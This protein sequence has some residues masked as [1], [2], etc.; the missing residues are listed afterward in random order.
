MNFISHHEVAWQY[1]PKATPSFRFGSFVTDLT[2]MSPTRRLLVGAT[3][4]ELLAGI[5]AHQLTNKAFDTQ[6]VISQL[7]EDMK[8]SFE[9]FLPWRTATQASRAGKDL[10][11]DGIQFRE[12]HVI[13]N[14]LTTL[15]SVL[16]DEV[17][18]SG[19]AD[20]GPLLEAVSWI[21]RNGPP[22]YD[23]TEV[24]ADRLIR[25]LS[26][27]RTPLSDSYFEEV[28]EVFE[29]HQPTVFAIGRLVMSQT[30]ENLKSMDLS[31]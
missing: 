20:S 12:D 2:R 18:F 17:E 25:T 6:T 11:F 15:D 9:Q 1:K 14:F 26:T 23:D 4:P 3:N 8:A 13:D 28:V 16:A 22:R 29:A 10:L 21:R 31:L 7:E 19:M 5:A 24:V 30:V 27:T